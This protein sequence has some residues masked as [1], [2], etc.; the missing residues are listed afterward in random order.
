MFVMVLKDAI[1]K[2][3]KIFPNDSHMV[4]FLMFLLI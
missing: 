4:M 2:K 3:K 1:S